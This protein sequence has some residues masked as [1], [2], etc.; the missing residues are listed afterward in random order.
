MTISTIYRVCVETNEMIYREY[1]HTP[2]YSRKVSAATE[3][4]IMSGQNSYSNVEEWAEYH[5]IKDAQACEKRLMD[6][7]YYFAGKLLK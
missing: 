5:T 2:E 4:S 7:S 6:M 3:G 1:G